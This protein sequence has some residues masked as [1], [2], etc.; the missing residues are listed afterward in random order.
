MRLEKVMKNIE[1]HYE[2]KG[3]RRGPISENDIC[4]LIQNGTLSA[5][6]LVW[7]KGFREWARL[8]DTDLS[9]YIA[10]SATTTSG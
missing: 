1:W 7:K 3:K 4:V 9:D 2:L 6:T 10:Y 8:A 5:E